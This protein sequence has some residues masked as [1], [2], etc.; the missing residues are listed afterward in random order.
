[1]LRYKKH[2]DIKD[3]AESELV[4]QLENQRQR[5]SVISIDPVNFAL[6]IVHTKQ[7]ITQLED[8][9]AKEDASQLTT[10]EKHAT[11]GRLRMLLGEH[12][13]AIQKEEQEHIAYTADVEAQISALQADIA[14]AEK[15]QTRKRQPTM[16]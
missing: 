12:L 4:Q 8:L 16:P 13:Q 3:L 5:L 9:I 14:N 6:D 15:L 1:M 10:G 2:F 11:G 7:R